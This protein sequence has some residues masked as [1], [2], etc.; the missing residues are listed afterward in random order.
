[1][2]YFVIFVLVIIFAS[3]MY[4]E[5]KN[6]N[7]KIRISLIFSLLAGLL[8]LGSYHLRVR[9]FENQFNN[10]FSNDAEKNSELI[11][12]GRVNSE[13][14]QNINACLGANT[15]TDKL[16]KIISEAIEK[17]NSYIKPS[18]ILPK[19]N[20]KKYNEEFKLLSKKLQLINQ[21]DRGTASSK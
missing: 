21:S 19:Y 15:D 7:K 5:L 3:L 14:L 13:F 12:V 11:E 17:Q 16:K 9:L 2:Y 18:M 10:M 4:Y 8:L 1:M 20:S 6:K